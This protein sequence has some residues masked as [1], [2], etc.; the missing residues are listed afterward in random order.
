MN[1]NNL[2]SFHLLLVPHFSEYLLLN[3]EILAFLLIL[4]F[5][6]VLKLSLSFIRNHHYMDFF[7]YFLEFNTRFINLHLILLFSY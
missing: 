3:L 7:F 2:Y 6:L 4:Y 1:I 5:I